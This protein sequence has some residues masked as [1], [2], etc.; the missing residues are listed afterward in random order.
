MRLCWYLQVQVLNFGSFFFLHSRTN[1]YFYYFLACF[2]E[3][4]TT[5]ATN[6]WGQWNIE[7]LGPFR[8]YFGMLNIG[9]NIFNEDIRKTTCTNQQKNI[10]LHKKHEHHY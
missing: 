3:L 10:L 7:I 4:G 1:R 2:L 5:G 9:L 6:Y 8:V